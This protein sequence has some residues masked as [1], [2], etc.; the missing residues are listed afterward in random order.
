M[1]FE[2]IPA[3]DLRNG[4]CVQL[5]QGVKESEI[6]SLDDPVGMAEHWVSQGAKRLHLIDLDGAFQER[7]RNLGIIREIIRSSELPLQVGGGIRTFD[8]ASSLLNIGVDRVILGTAAIKN[9]EMASKLADE[10][11]ADRIMVALDSKG[12]EVKIEGWTEGSGLSPIE[13]ALNCRDFVGSFLFTNIDVE[14][15]LGGIQLDPIIDLVRATDIPV[16]VA[17]GISQME[18]IEKVVSSGANGVVIGTAIYKKK[19][20]LKEAIDKYGSVV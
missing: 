10:F 18:D 2:V 19:I 9:P 11:S 20:I 15:L 13:V 5:V 17:G 1:G 12:G 4:R 3:V 7:R 8:D 14:G 6:V 16:I